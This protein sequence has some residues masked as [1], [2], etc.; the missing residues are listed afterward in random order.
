MKMAQ[1]LTKK[2]TKSIPI[3]KI[4]KKYSKFLHS[5]RKS[6]FATEFKYL[7]NI[8]SWEKQI[9][10]TY[11][12]EDFLNSQ[13]FW[14]SLYTKD[15]HLPYRKGVLYFIIKLLANLVIVS[16]KSHKGGL[17]CLSDSD[18]KGGNCRLSKLVLSLKSSLL[19]MAFALA[20]IQDSLR[21]NLK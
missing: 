10:K 13:N 8:D 12:K 1:I 4:I 5:L 7:F 9:P 2:A 20:S 15:K 6:I 14:Y 16:N 11:S 17:C 3:E 18:S 19:C 21:I